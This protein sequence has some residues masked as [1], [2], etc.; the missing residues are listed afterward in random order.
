MT[1][2]QAAFSRY[3]LQYDPDQRDR[4]L[5]SAADAVT[6]PVAL[7]ALAGL[8]VSVLA[9]RVV[10][11]RRRMALPTPEPARW[12]D[13]LLTVLAGHGFV[14]DPGATPREFAEGVAAALHLRPATAPLAEV[15]VEWAEA[16]YQTRFGGIALPGDRQRVL[17]DRLTEL[18]RVLA[19]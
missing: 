15:P 16:Y 3:F 2:G 10:L 19:A 18:A 12:F 4:L 1:R 13:H 5:G 17:E 8:V 11:R 6:N 7:A 14:P 9:G